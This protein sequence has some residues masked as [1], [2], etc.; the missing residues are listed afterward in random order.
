MADTQVTVALGATM[1]TGNFESLR[2]DY[3]V[4]DTVRAGE[5]VNEAIDRVEKVVEDRLVKRM[6]D[7]SA[8][9]DRS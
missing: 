8:E 6:A 3:S 7:E 4:T 2:I 9:L 5:R 1:N